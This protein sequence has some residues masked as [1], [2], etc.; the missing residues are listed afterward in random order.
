MITTKH[1]VKL[2]TFALVGTMLVS[3]APRGVS[4]PRSSPSTEEGQKGEV[5]APRAVQVMGGATKEEDAYVACLIGQAAVALHKKCDAQAA[6][7]TAYKICK[8]RGRL[9]QEGIEG[10]GDYV[11]MKV[12]S[13]AG[14]CK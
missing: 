6:Q 8:F 11:N 1:A 2:A 3:M 10:I 7:A 5:D 13:M 4:A 9:T 14:D 12:D